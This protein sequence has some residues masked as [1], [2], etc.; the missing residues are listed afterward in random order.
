MSGFEK[1]VEQIKEMVSNGME[2]KEAIKE[3]AW[4]FGLLISELWGEF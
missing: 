3:T 2:L 1:A 4:E